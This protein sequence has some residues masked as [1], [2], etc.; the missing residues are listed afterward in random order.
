MKPEQIL[1]EALLGLLPEGLEQL[2]VLERQELWSEVV[3]GQHSKTKEAIN[4][5]RSGGFNDAR[6]EMKK[7]IESLDLPTLIERISFGSSAGKNTTIQ[8]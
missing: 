5:I 7:N 2:T 8:K 3:V 6:A 1:R 4:E